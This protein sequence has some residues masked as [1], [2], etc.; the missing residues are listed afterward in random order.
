[1]QWQMINNLLNRNQK[2]KSAIKLHN[3]GGDIVSS[4]DEVSEKFNKY[5][6]NI[7]TNIKAKISVSQPFDPGGQTKFLNNPVPNSIFLTPSTDTEIYDIIKAFKNKATLDTR[8]GALKAASNSVSFLNSMSTVI[9]KSLEEGFFPT[10]LKTARVI[11]I[12][13]AGSKTEVSNY[14]PIS[15][16]STFSKIYEKI[17]HGRVLNFLESNNSLHDMCNMASDQEGLVSTHFSLHK[18][19]SKMPCHGSKSPSSC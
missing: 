16:L 9:N 14:R 10:A 4:N 1:M 5:F 17:M 7:A 2:V 15:L 19:Q 6:S 12:H 3:D 11:P 8:I 18:I 13:K